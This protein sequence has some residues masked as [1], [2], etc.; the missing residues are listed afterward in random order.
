MPEETIDRANELDDASTDRALTVARDALTTDMSQDVD[1]QELIR[2]NN[3]S[4]AAQMRAEDILD[5]R[6]ERRQ[7]EEQ[8]HMRMRLQIQQDGQAHLHGSELNKQA[9]RHNDHTLIDLHNPKKQ[10]SAEL[11]TSASS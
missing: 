2:S 10:D 1:T 11:G 4:F 6:Q 5:R 9:V 8:H 7:Q 3:Q